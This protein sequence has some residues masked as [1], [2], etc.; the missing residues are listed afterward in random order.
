M[1]LEFPET[2]GEA[3]Q[4]SLGS[5]EQEFSEKDVMSTLEGSTAENMLGISI[6]CR[7]MDT[8]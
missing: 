2:S 4:L 6:H 3:E 7:C 5:S 1:P 8:N